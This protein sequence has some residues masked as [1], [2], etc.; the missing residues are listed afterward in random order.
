ML[1]RLPPAQAWAAASV[2][3]F[4]ENDRAQDQQVRLFIE[5]AF[6]AGVGRGIGDEVSTRHI[7]HTTEYR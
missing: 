1:L 5:T 4:D 2:R 3:V 7:T 6:W